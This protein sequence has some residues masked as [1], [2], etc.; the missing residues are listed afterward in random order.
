[1][2]V[3][4][5]LCAKHHTRTIASLSQTDSYIPL[6]STLRHTHTGLIYGH[7]QQPNISNHYLIRD[8]NSLPAIRAL[9]NKS[10][11]VWAELML[12]WT[13]STNEGW[14]P[15][16][17]VCVFC[18]WW[19]RFGRCTQCSFTVGILS[20]LIPAWTPALPLQ[21]NTCTKQSLLILDL[22]KAAEQDDTS[23]SQDVSGH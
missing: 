6:W 20:I 7:C 9:G 15:C 19:T 3:C 1:M 18:M 16:V 2:C 4:T 11:P 13:Y 5:R 10:L 22:V 23:R 21:I 12:A 17:F 8:E 14:A